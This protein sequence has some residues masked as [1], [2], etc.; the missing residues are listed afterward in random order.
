MLGE[1]GLL[2]C[3]LLGRYS[4]LTSLYIGLIGI[5]I[6]ATVKCL[7]VIRNRARSKGLTSF[8]RGKQDRRRILISFRDLGVSIS[9]SKS[10][11]LLRLVKTIDYV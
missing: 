11:S 9:I 3:I 8:R 5:V 7:L 1:S 2:D 6:Q 10:Y 4:G